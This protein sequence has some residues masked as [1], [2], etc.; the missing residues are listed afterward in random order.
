VKLPGASLAVIEDAKL[1]DYLL[2]S[3]HSIGR[4]KAAFFARFGYTPDKWRSLKA[5][6]LHL[7]RSE[8]ARP[9]QDSAYGR[10][11]EVCGI[12]KGPNGRA[13]EI[14]TVWIVLQQERTPRF[15][16]AYPGAKQ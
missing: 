10:K 13:L 4:Y 5:D 2:S 15:I 16:T 8:E 3:T 12:I 1:R 9:A 7:V 11:Y 6:L 14:V